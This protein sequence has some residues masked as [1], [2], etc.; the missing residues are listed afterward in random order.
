MNL[1]WENLG[2]E[3]LPTNGSIRVDYANGSWS[4][5][6]IYEKDTVE[7]PLGAQVLHYG[8]ACFEGLKAYT[9]K[10]GSISMF[11][12]DM[13][14][15]RMIKSAERI[16]MQAPPEEVF[17]DACKQ[18]V[19]LNKEFVPPYG[20]G[21]S[22]YIRPLLIGTEA[23]FAIKP[24]Q[25]Y[26]FYV[27]V[28]PVGPYYKDGFSAVDALVL[29]DFDRAAPHGTGQSKVAG[30]YAASLKGSMLANSEGYPIVLYLDSKEGKY[31]DEF[32]TSNFIGITPNNEYITPKSSSILPSII[33]DSLKVIAE[34]LGLQVLHKPISIDQI[35]QFCEVGACGTAAI[36]T[37]IKSIT[38][39]NFKT[40]YSKKSNQNYLQKLYDH[41]QGIQNGD[42]ADKFHWNVAVK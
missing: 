18:A 31:I 38:C 22:L 5:P 41:L 21:A 27:M 1:D 17:I 2:F 42:I 6:Q 15:K 32:G 39:D 29:K 23:M 19:K 4:E 9:L 16:C 24:S 10:D 8:Q 20:S 7:L 34:D 13:N 30:N 33:N 40:D 11:R 25:T 28:S 12:P 36:I 37:P 14:A 3:Q 35:D 26:S